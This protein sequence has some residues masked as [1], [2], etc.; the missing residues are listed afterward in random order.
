MEVVQVAKEVTRTEVIE[1]LRPRLL[2]Q[3]H[4]EVAC[5]DGEMV[6]RS[7][8]APR[9]HGSGRRDGLSWLVLAE[10][11]E[12]CRPA[13]SCGQARMSGVNR[14]GGNAR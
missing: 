7:S 11:H 2:G 9:G 14:S 3:R 8:A 6:R 1:A 4:A 10:F 13:A 5:T 12:P